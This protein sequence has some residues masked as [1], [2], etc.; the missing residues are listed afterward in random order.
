MPLDGGVWPSAAPQDGFRAPFQLP[1]CQQQQAEVGYCGWYL[2][3]A[4]CKDLTRSL[5]L[6]QREGSLELVLLVMLDVSAGIGPSR[7]E[8]P[9]LGQGNILES[10]PSVR[11]AW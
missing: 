6:F 3:F 7:P 1:A 8:A 10:T 2:V 4:S 5:G 11:F 9:D